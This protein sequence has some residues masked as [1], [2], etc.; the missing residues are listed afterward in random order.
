MAGS[1]SRHEWPD[2]IILEPYNYLAGNVGKELRRDLIE[3]FNHWLLVPTERIR[4]VSTVVHLLHNASLIIDDIEDGSNLRR[5]RPAAHC[6]FGVPT[7]INSAN[8]VYFLALNKLMELNHP[9]AVAIFTEQMLELHRGQGMDIYWRSSFHC[10]T[11]SEYREMAVKK[12][13]G[14]FGLAVR[15]MQLFS[16]NKDNFK[17]L[18]DALGLL[19]QIRDDY[20][21]LVDTSYHKSKTYADDLTEGKFSYPIVQAIRNFPHDNQV[22]SIL[23]QRTTDLSLK[24]HCVRHMA[25]LGVLDA[26]VNM[27]GELEAKCIELIRDHGGNPLL[28]EFV[29]KLGKLYR[30]ENGDLVRHRPS[31]FDLEIKSQHTV[32]KDREFPNKASVSE[33]LTKNLVTENGG[34]AC[35]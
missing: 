12:T 13:G 10:P 23:Y 4:T 25:E 20:A 28:S 31:D 35:T 24:R 2:E 16:E 33:L 11:E 27:L 34:P 26:T 19:F 29:H 18:L 17:P 3:A 6:V 8:Y 7:S 1:S 15:L 22:Q 21:N 30:T 32:C 14:L 5:G 9:E